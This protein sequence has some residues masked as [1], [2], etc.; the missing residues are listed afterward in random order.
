VQS[1]C[2]CTAA[3]FGLSLLLICS[4][5]SASRTG[6]E[7]E[8]SFIEKAKESLTDK[9]LSLWTGAIGTLLILVG[10]VILDAAL[11]TLSSPTFQKLL[12]PLLALSILANA[13]LIVTVW[14]VTSRQK[15]RKRFGFLW[16]ADLQ[17]HC[18][19]CGSPI[20]WGEWAGTNGWGFWCAKCKDAMYL[21]DDSGQHISIEEARR[22]LSEKK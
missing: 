14:A 13:G 5:P 2:S 21:R 17:P 1:W 10:G 20:Q 18:P 3:L 16:D 11:P 19:A 8:K 7:M 12:L 15:L 22:R 4:I 6:L 9:A